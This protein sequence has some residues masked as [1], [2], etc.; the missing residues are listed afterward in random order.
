[1]HFLSFLEVTDLSLLPLLPLLPLLLPLTLP[2]PLRLRRRQ[3]FAGHTGVALGLDSQCTWLTRS[4][5]K[6]LSLVLS[7]MNRRQSSLPGFRR[8][9]RRR[10]WLLLLRLLRRLLLLRLLLLRLLLRLLFRLLWLLFS[11]LPFGK[12]SPSVLN[13]AE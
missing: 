6:Q 5:R 4:Q 11:V 9:H 7:Y 2:L 1:M 8:S 3:D 10:P 13:R 12:Q